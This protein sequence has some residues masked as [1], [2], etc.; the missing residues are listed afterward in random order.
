MLA[1][2]SITAPIFLLIGLGYGAVRWRIIPTETVPG[3]GRF[4]LYF[5]MPGLILSTLSKMRIE[6]V[7]DPGFMLAYGLGSLLLM[8]IGL[9]GFRLWRQEPVLASLKT[10]GM[11]MPNTPYFGFPVLLQVV[12]SVAGQALALAMLVEAL[13]IIPLSMALLEFYSSRDGNQSLGQVLLTLPKRVLRNP[14]IIAILVGLLFALLEL[15]LPPALTTTLD[16][17]G[18]SSA[19]V[20][21]FVI[22]A[23]LVGSPLRGQVGG[24]MPVLAGKLIAHPLLVG[25]MIWLLPPFNP[26]LQLALL[27]LAAMPM[28]SIYPIFGSQYGHRHFAA[29]TL[30]LTT[31]SAFITISVLLLFIR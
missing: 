6:D 5:A 2:L 3:L 4:V 25:L 22:G 31:I 27:L 19:A 11:V 12:D 10:M 9:L 15:R 23:S 30:L 8:G 18:R 16:M 24:M 17:L 20:A 13:L 21:L 1:I 26:D 14:M 28:M 29:G 7:I